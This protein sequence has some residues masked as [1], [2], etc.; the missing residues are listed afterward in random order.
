LDRWARSVRPSSRTTESHVRCLAQPLHD[1]HAGRR[2]RAGRGDGLPAVHAAQ[3]FGCAGVAGQ[4]PSAVV[5]GDDGAR[6]GAR[7]GSK[8]FVLQWRALFVCALHCLTGYPSVGAS[9]HVDFLQQAQHKC[10]HACAG[11]P[12]NSQVPRAVQQASPLG[13]AELAGD[14]LANGNSTGQ[15]LLKFGLDLGIAF[16]VDG[17]A[18][19]GYQWQDTI[20][21][22]RAIELMHVGVLSLAADRMARTFAS[23]DDGAPHARCHGGLQTGPHSGAVVAREALCVVHQGASGRRRPDGVVL[24]HRWAQNSCGSGEW[25]VRR[26]AS[27]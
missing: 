15:G 23:G 7:P 17:R 12:Q 27:T 2:T 9:A 18:V 10:E 16:V 19:D 11:V 5:V 21:T 1:S 3:A 26:A 6:N 22:R 8:A 25:P 13:Q 4:T 20:G 24:R 14:A